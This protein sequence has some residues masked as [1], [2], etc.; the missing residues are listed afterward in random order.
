MKRGR[1]PS[2]RTR[3]RLLSNE[4]SMIS[5]TATSRVL[6]IAVLFASA[7]I[8]SFVSAQDTVWTRR[9]DTGQYDMALSGARDRFGGLLLTGISSDEHGSGYAVALT[10]KYDA[11][12]DTSWTRIYGANE[13]DVSLSVAV[14][15]DGNVVAV[16]YYNGEE[17][18]GSE[19]LRYDR[20]GDLLWVRLD[21]S[22]VYPWFRGVAIDDSMNIIACG[23]AGMQ[24]KDALLAKYSSS[25]ESLWAKTF[26]FG[27]PIDLFSRVELDG[28]G[29]II[30]VGLTGDNVS[31]DLLTAKFSSEGDLMWSSRLDLSPYDG[32]GSIAFDSDDNIIISGSTGDTWPGSRQGLLVKY[33]PGG[34][35]IWTKSYDLAFR[36]SMGGIALDQTGNIVIAGTVGDSVQGRWRQRCLLVRCDS[37]GDTIGTWRYD[38]DNNTSGYDIACDDAGYIYV[39]GTEEPPS[40]EDYLLL[41]L[42][43]GAGFEENSVACSQ[44]R[45]RVYVGVNPLRA[46]L[47]LRL[48]IPSSERYEISLFNVAG[49]RSATVHSGPLAQ[50]VH[51]FNP[52]QL[53]A[54]VY[55]LRAVGPKST[56]TE[57]LVVTE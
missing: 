7:P 47:P 17:T 34:D 27:R 5:S 38:S 32:A 40:D 28:E 19:M 53:R 10:V 26:D 48:A 57:R 36:A 20:D 2:T 49:R 44:S 22:D 56:E 54:G 4:G 41:K 12:G 9:F 25:G 6:N 24:Y 33:A 1:V 21:S 29:N 52:G 14:D 8:C 35:T 51:D 13:D 16:G 30:C 23:L 42:R 15:S 37:A 39:F 11:S 55:L 3:L 46:G 43:H 50:G 31:A 18:S 45:Q